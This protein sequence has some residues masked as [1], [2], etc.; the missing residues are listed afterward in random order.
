MASISE[1]F[2]IVNGVKQGGVMSPSCIIYIIY[3]DNLIDI[4]KKT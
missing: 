1:Q 3:I 2:T 4:L